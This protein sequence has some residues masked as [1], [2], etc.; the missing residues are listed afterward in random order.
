MVAQIGSQVNT[1][2]R[3]GV[4]ARVC[5]VLAVHATSA[6]DLTA[7]GDLLSSVSLLADSTICFNQNLKLGILQSAYKDLRNAGVT[8]KVGPRPAVRD[9]EQL[10]PKIALS[11]QKGQL[12]KRAAG[13]WVAAISKD[14]G[15]QQ[16]SESALLA[17]KAINIA[18]MDTWTRSMKS[19]A[20]HQIEDQP[21]PGSLTTG[22]SVLD[23][24]AEKPG[25]GFWPVRRVRPTMTKFQ[26]KKR[27][28]FSRGRASATLI[29]VSQVLLPHLTN[30]QVE[31][32][33]SMLGYEI[34]RRI[35]YNRSDHYIDSGQAPI[36]MDQSRIGG[37]RP[38]LQ[39]ELG[40]TMLA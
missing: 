4:S 39:G 34:D 19:S 15:V 37:A 13:A 33:L 3:R 22:E 17:G 6:F 21:I 28:L 36:I 38:C 7:D 12:G 40:I 18:A 26:R 29:R 20:D 24:P 32:K 14:L 2:A 31:V 27:T 5:A 11:L 10:I 9:E 35:S 1:L 23:V 25:T 30:R 8:N 16:T